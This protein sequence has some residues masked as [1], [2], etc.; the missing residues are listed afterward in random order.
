[1]ESQQGLLK[2]VRILD[3]STV[4]AG[5]YCTM[6]LADLG[7]EVIKIENPQGGVFSGDFSRVG[8]QYHVGGIGAYFLAVNRNKKSIGIDLSTSKG[9]SVFHDLVRLSDVVFD[10]SKPSALAKMGADPETL[11]KIKPD[12]ICCSLSGFGKTGP[13]SNLAAYDITI[14]ARGGSMGITGEPGRSPVRMGLA[15]GDLAGSLFSALAITA[16]LFKKQKSEVGSALD[17]ALLDC[18]V[19]LLT[20]L[21]EYY[22]VGGLVAGPQGSGHET[23]VPYRA[24]KAKDYYFTIACFNDKHWQAACKAMDRQDL[25]TDPR[26]S[27]AGARYANSDLV[28]K[29]LEEI[30]LT[31]TVEEWGNRFSEHQVAWGP[32]NTIDRTLNDP[33]V[34]A[35]NMVVDVKHPV[36]GSYKSVG[37]PIKTSDIEEAFNPVPLMGQHSREILMNLLKYDGKTINQLFE[38]NVVGEQTPNDLETLLETVAML[39]ADAKAQAAKSLESIKKG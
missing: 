16:A 38:E 33:Q 21:S 11:K 23:L 4:L 28:N 32:I 35:R 8:V 2:G 1:M 25:I 37:N 6:L 14:Q 26:F 17:V 34:L 13:L 31:R 30:F 3:L 24:Y 7:A 39:Q 36:S 19:S 12:I 18:Q 10:N 20:Y 5:P 15:M 22:L 29:A 27:N 9:Q